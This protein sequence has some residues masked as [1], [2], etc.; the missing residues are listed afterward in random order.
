MISRDSP[1][2]MGYG[3][4]IARGFPL[5]NASVDLLRAF[6]P[7][8]PPR[9]SPL[10]I[11]PGKPRGNVRG[12]FRESPREWGMGDVCMY[13]DGCA[14]AVRGGGNIIRRTSQ[15]FLLLGW[16]RRVHI[17]GHRE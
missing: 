2:P 14:V 16:P 1:L 5:G 15:L 10:G 13:R 7:E 8:H 9:V 11:Y 3:K 6:H 12:F 4:E 17:A